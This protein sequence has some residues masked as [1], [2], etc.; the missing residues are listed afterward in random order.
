M[1]YPGGHEFEFKYLRPS[2]MKVD[3]LYQRE[4]DTK[5][6]AQIV[7]EWNGDRFN[8]PKVSYRDGSLWIFNG[9][10]TTAAWK[11]LHNNEDKPIY[12]KVFK[13]MT[14]LEECEAFVEQNGI[15]KDPTS[16][17]KLKA[18]YNSHDPDV[19]DMVEKAKLC[20]FVVDFKMSKTPTRIVATSALIRAYKNIGGDAFLD[21]LTAIKEAWYGDE[22][23]IC[24]Q[25]ITGLATF[26]KIYGGNFSRDK[27]VS[28]LKDTTPAKIRAKGKDNTG[29]TNTYTREIVKQYNIRKR[30]SKLDEGKLG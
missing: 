2:Q 14:W 15:S 27:L 21:M 13:G 7:K 28:A 8:E 20:G 9:Q 29:R 22:D 23:A 11:H 25:I 10:H 18:A 19:I 16:N 3:R 4:L 1:K 17:E 24:A 26:Y 12:C 5:R 6:V 30:S